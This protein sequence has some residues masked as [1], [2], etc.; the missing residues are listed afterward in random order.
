MDVGLPTLRVEAALTFMPRVFTG[1]YVLLPSWA[2]LR[3][4][5]WADL[6]L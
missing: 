6:S 2:H 3:V 4:D 5:Q 1:K